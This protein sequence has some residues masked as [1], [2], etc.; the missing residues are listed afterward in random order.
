ML[1]CHYVMV[2]FILLL[3]YSVHYKSTFIF[4]TIHCRQ[5][6]GISAFERGLRAH[7]RLGHGAIDP[8]CSVLPAK[9]ASS[10]DVRV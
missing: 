1:L 2:L 7:Q 5:I 4:F 8:S 9:D 10:K 6:S 3:V